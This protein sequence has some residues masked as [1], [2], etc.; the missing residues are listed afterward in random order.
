MDGHDVAA[1]DAAI[2][3]AQKSDKPTLICCKTVIGKGSPNKAG[4][5]KAHGSPL[6]EDEIAAT[7]KAIGWEYPPFEIPEDVYTA[8]DARKKGNELESAW[9]SLFEKYSEKYPEEARE[10]M[11]RISGEVPANFEEIVRN[12]IADC[13]AKRKIS[14]PARQARMPLRHSPR[15][16]R[17]FSADRPI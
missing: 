1:V 12:Y 10:L 14:P 5:N 15:L 8:W 4:L 9:N 3:A 16:C 7:R 6:G 17:S 13:T 11:R 2:I